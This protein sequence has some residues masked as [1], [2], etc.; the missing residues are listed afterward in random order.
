MEIEKAL[1]LA[2]RRELLAKKPKECPVC[3]ETQQIQLLDWIQL[4]EWWR[5]RK[6]ST[7]FKGDA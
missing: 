3:H 7:A 5:C 1:A 6:C 4:P 2:H